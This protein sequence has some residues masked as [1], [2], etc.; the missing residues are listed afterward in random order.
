MTLVILWVPFIIVAMIMG[1][2]SATGIGMES[3]SPRIRVDRL[4][5]LTG[6][7]GP[8]ILVLW[9]LEHT[10]EWARRWVI[11]EPEMP[12]HLRAAG[13]VTQADVERLSAEVKA[14][15]RPCFIPHH[16]C[17]ICGET[18]THRSAHPMPVFFRSLPDERLRQIFD[19]LSA[20]EKAVLCAALFEGRP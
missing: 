17:G 6:F 20:E 19:S 10:Q 3:V 7:L 15:K 11:R 14:D 2:G 9:A 16:P 12:E 13:A 1:F 18:V 4:A 5:L 8:I